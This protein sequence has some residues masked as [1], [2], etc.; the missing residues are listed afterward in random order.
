MHAIPVI[1]QDEDDEVDDVVTHNHGPQVEHHPH[2]QSNFMPNPNVIISSRPSSQL[3]QNGSSGYGSTRSQVGPFG[4]SNRPSPSSSSSST[5]S[6]DNNSGNG[7]SNNQTKPKKKR[8]VWFGGSLRGRAAS[9][10]ESSEQILEAGSGN[11]STT[12]ITSEIK[13]RG[14]PQYASLRI[15]NRIQQATTSFE[16]R[17]LDLAE[18]EVDSD[19][20]ANNNNNDNKSGG[21]SSDLTLT[22]AHNGYYPLRNAGSLEAQVYFFSF[23]FRIFFKICFLHFFFF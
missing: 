9:N 4:T 21:Q 12:A 2:E 3:S 1:V 18:A 19:T 20:E 23:F 10:S 7:N 8:S 17:G 13:T 22:V 5:N 6:S 16:D 11:S 14:Q 15:P